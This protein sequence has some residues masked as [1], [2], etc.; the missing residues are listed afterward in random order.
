MTHPPSLDE[1]L[2]ELGKRY[3]PALHWEVDDITRIYEI[4]IGNPM[5][6]DGFRL[7]CDCSDSDGPSSGDE[8]LAHM[9]VAYLNA[10]RWA[11]HLGEQLRQAEQVLNEQLRQAERELKEMRNRVE[12]FASELEARGHHGP[13]GQIRNEILTGP[14]EAPR[15]AELMAAYETEQAR[16]EMLIEIIAHAIK[17]DLTKQ[18]DA[19][20]AAERYEL[21]RE[22]ARRAMP[23]LDVLDRVSERFV[24]GGFAWHILCFEEINDRRLLRDWNEGKPLGYSSSWHLPSKR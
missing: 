9:L 12:I 21:L 5:R 20:K 11:L 4:S 24:W 16:T 7:V 15:W 2:E 3:E 22:A 6:V 14:V 19:S 10:G 23:A 18:T 8:E 17:L 13:A 1:A